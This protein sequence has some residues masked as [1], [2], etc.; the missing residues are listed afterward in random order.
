M[1]KRTQESK[2][3]ADASN[4]NDTTFDKYTDYFGAE[5]RSCAALAGTH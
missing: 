4:E 5:K 3:Q 2:S 1:A